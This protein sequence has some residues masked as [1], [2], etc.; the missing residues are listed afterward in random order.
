VDTPDR[1][2]LGIVDAG[3]LGTSLA[4]ALQAAG[5]RVDA[6]SRRDRARAHAAASS[7]GPHVFA[8]DTPQEVVDRADV[9]F[10][11]TVDDRIAPLAAEL[12]FRA[13]QTVLHC[14]GATPVAALATAERAG[15]LVGG[16]H[17]LQTFPDE[18]G[19]GRFAGITFGI[20]AREPGLL[21]WLQELAGALGGRTVVLDPE[22]RPLYHASAVMTG[23]LTAALA[24]LAAGLWEELGQNREAGLHAL[25]PLL[26][27]TAQSVAT[28]GIPA[29]LT[30]PFVRGDVEPVRR[31]LQAL[32]DAHPETGRAYA[33]LALAQLPIA[34]ERGNIPGDRM[35]ELRALLEAVAHATGR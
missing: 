14:S 25:A 11:T 33:A 35:H 10:L 21:V 17:P 4:A 2:S 24:G 27:H 13:G 3:R 5:Y 15:A 32:A 29:A 8:T 31:H 26:L 16:L 18:H 23:P 7:L 28:L 6:L 1:P 9:V 19:A 20:E 30:G 22:S 12:R 34:A